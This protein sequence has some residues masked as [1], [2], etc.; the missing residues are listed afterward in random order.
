MLLQR[1]FVGPLTNILFIIIF[2]Y[3]WRLELEVQAPL[4]CRV[5][6]GLSWNAAQPC[7][8]DRFL[9]HTHFLR[10]SLM[11]M[12][13]STHPFTFTLPSRQEAACEWLSRGCCCFFSPFFETR[14]DYVSPPACVRVRGRMF[15]SLTN[16]LLILLL[17]Q[18]HVCVF[19]LSLSKYEMVF[20]C[21]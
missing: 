11:D 21:C 2:I 14:M 20:E 8:G 4:P 6:T 19:S 17:C 5:P 1:N 3:M 16:R 15:R 12:V 10:V 7:N 18:L 9:L 13:L